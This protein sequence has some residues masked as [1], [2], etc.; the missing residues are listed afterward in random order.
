MV[1]FE[2][3]FADFIDRRE[4]DIA[5]NALFSMIR[6]AF[7]A[8]W[9]AAEGNPPQT[10]KVIDIYHKPIEEISY[11]DYIETDIK[12][13]DESKKQPTSTHI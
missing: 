7:K 4:Y 11:A 2:K 5:E 13:K 1:E 8:G 3:A 9:L 12:L 6:I 10:Q